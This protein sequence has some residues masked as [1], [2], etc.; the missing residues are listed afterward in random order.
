MK[1]CWLLGLSTDCP[2]C[3]TLAGE[4]TCCRAIAIGNERYEEIPAEIIKTAAYRALGDQRMKI[5]IVSDGKFGDQAY[6][7]IREKTSDRMD[8]GSVPVGNYGGRF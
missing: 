6:E 7:I 3:G 1:T 4:S 2:S 8:H 5:G